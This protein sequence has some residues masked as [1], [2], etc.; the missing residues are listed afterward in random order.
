MNP[1]EWAI[2]SLYISH[3]NKEA[4][5]WPSLR[6]LQGGRGK[7]KNT[8]AAAKAG[9]VKLGILVPERQARPGGKFGRKPFRVDFGAMFTVAQKLG[10][11]GTDTQKTVT[12][13]TDA[14][15]PGKEGNR[16]IRCPKREG[17]TIET[18]DCDYLSKLPS[19][20]EKPE[21]KTRNRLD[22]HRLSANVAR[23][24]AESGDQFMVEVNSKPPIDRGAE[25]DERNREAY[26]FYANH[27][28]EDLNFVREFFNFPIGEDDATLGYRFVEEAA[29]VGR[30]CQEKGI[31]PGVAACK[32]IDRCERLMGEGD[33]TWW[34]PSFAEHRRRLLEEENRAKIESTPQTTEVKA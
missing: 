1:A 26:A 28:R 30:E 31:S 9:L 18:S 21:K 32:V 10:S 23:K 6:S 13:K 7:G 8:V 22:R 17:N 29:D 19:R 27:L 2:L 15:K 4:R 5:A 11:G 14:Q 24:L 25:E 20:I 33:S 12:Q 3:A 34:P 16:N